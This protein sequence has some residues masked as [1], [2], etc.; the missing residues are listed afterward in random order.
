MLFPL[1]Y[2]S[3]ERG[4]QVYGTVKIVVQFMKEK[5]NVSPEK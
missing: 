4:N 3:Q 2:C 5:V 1:Q